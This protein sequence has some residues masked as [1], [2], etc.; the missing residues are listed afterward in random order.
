M[1]FGIWFVTPLAAY[2]ATPRS[3]PR[4]VARRKI[5]PRLVSTIHAP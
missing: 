4:P 5:I 1:I 3:E 2:H